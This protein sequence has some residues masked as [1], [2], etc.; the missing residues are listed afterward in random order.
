MGLF[1]ASWFDLILIQKKIFH[2]TVQSHRVKNLHTLLNSCSMTIDYPDRQN[3]GRGMSGTHIL[4]SWGRF[5][6]AL[7]TI[8]ANIQQKITSDTSSELSQTFHCK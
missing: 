5:C 7:G 1:T 3:C 6:Y 2:T 4:P 8:Y